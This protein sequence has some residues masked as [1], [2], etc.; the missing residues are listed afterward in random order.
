M[1]DF[2]VRGEVSLAL[3][4]RWVLKAGSEL[5]VLVNISPIKKE[6]SSFLPLAVSDRRPAVPARGQ[7]TREPQGVQRALTHR[8]NTRCEDLPELSSRSSQ[9][10]SDLDGLG[11]V[12]VATAR[13]AQS[14][15]PKALN[16]V[17]VGSS[18]TVGDCVLQLDAAGK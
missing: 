3:S 5:S 13:L 8:Y 2:L 18:P 11:P 6:S 15:E 1:L 12:W 10:L 16:L 14:A 4:L 17:V 9:A 7:V